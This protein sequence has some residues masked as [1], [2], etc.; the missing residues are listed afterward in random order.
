M[1]PGAIV[2]IL[3]EE[4]IPIDLIILKT[5]D[6]KGGLYIETKNLDGETNLKNKSVSKDIN[7]NF[8]ESA[9]VKMDHT[10]VS[11]LPNNAIYKFEGYMQDNQSGDKIPLGADNMVLRG[12]KLRNTEWVIGVSIFSGHDTKIMMNSAKAKYKFS[13][14]EK[15]SNKAIIL[16]FITQMVLAAIGAAIQSSWTI[17][18]I[19]QW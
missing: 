8:S 11:E 2:K 12:C 13:T 19:Q 7:N 9:V 5:S 3:D 16:V 17:Q 15:N 14:L 18:N 6:E 1:Y 4:F 10:I